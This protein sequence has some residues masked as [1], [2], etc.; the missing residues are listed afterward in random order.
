M[1]SLATWWT[2]PRE[3]TMTGPAGSSLDFRMTRLHI[4][5]ARAAL[6][7]LEIAAAPAAMGATLEPAT[8]LS[9]TRV[10]ITELNAIEG[11]LAAAS[12]TS[13]EPVRVPCAFCGK[14]IMADATLCGFCWRRKA[15]PAVAH[16][17][18]D[19]AVASA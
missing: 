2:P 4:Q 15:E 13:T 9:Q 7:T 18:M 12:E 16:P 1:A 14:S 11:M 5:A 8:V 10:G 17:A 3:D 6:Q 19:S